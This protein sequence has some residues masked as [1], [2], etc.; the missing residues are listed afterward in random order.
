MWSLSFRVV[1]VANYWP[2]VCQ[3]KSTLERLMVGDLQI[4]S[5]I[6]PKWQRTQEQDTESIDFVRLDATRSMSI[7]EVVARRPRNFWQDVSRVG[8]ERKDHDK[9]VD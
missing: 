7:K 8:C 4:A 9:L 2:L 5:S 3:D 1:V 6:N